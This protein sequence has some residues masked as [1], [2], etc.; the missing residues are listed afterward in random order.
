LTESR[1]SKET[2][3]GVFK[4]LGETIFSLLPQKTMRV[5]M[6]WRDKRRRVQKRFVLATG[7]DA[8]ERN[9]IRH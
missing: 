5:A 7:L 8:S 4:S 2:I 6:R 9:A 1:E 3:D